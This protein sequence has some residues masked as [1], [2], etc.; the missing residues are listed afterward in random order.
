MTCDPTATRTRDQGLTDWSEVNRSHVRAHLA[1]IL[2]GHSDSYANQQYRSLR[3][4]FAFL[5][6]DEGIANPMADV[7][8]PRIAEKLIPLVSDAEWNALT[9]TCSGKT[10][11]DEQPE[12]VGSGFLLG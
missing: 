2:E 11:L 6:E 8:P 4:F 10:F 5:E 9:G 1:H 7:K 3:R 12:R